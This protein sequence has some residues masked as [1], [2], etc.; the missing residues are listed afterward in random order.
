LNSREISPDIF[1]S[2]SHRIFIIKCFVYFDYTL[3]KHRIMGTLKKAAVPHIAQFRDGAS[4]TEDVDVSIGGC[5]SLK[6]M[7][8]LPGA[9]ADLG[10][11]KGGAIIGKNTF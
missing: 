7:L 4:P 1:Q 10:F 3:R 2:F 8:R 11:W 9:V 6:K 5:A